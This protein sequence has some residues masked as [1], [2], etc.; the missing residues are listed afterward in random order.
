MSAH[1]LLHIGC[2]V[3]VRKSGCFLCKRWA[4]RVKNKVALW[5]NGGK[6]KFPLELPLCMVVLLKPGLE[7]FEHYFTSV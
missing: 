2:L 4:V 5:E 7:N 6:R 3:D 1:C